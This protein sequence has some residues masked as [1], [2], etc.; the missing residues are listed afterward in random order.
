MRI[1]QLL[2]PACLAFSLLAPGC[3]NNEIADPPIRESLTNLV[4]PVTGLP[5]CVAT[6][7]SRTIEF[8]GCD[9]LGASFVSASAQDQGRIAVRLAHI[10]GSAP[11]LSGIGYDFRRS[12]DS[13]AVAFPFGC[14]S[15]GPV[16]D[17]Q[18]T[19]FLCAPLGSADIGAFSSAAGDRELSLEYAVV[20]HPACNAAAPQ[21]S[22]LVMA[23]QGYVCETGLADVSK[24]FAPTARVQQGQAIFPSLWL[25]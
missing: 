24:N 5:L 10:N 21:V 3:F 25:R 4:D 13:A 18:A 19:E 22:K 16:L 20:S 9:M 1:A 8:K 11:D 17:G 2:I 7:G 14:T 15:N 23:N 6:Q 12:T